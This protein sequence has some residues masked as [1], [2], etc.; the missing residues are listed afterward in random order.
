M[1]QKQHFD[2]PPEAY[3]AIKTLPK[4]EAIAVLTSLAWAFQ[5]RADLNAIERQAVKMARYMLWEVDT[6]VKS[7]P[8]P[9]P[10]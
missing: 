3:A 5:N 6:L 2:L 8:D 4:D 7:F 10:A 9:V 1:A